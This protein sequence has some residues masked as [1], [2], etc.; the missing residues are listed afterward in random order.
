MTFLK[1]ISVEVALALHDMQVA[2]HGGRRG[3]VN[4][5]QLEAAL[6]R[7]RNLLNYAEPDIA[8]LAASYAY[9]LAN[10]H[11]FVDGNK[12]VS[13]VVTYAFL[14]LNGFDLAIEGPEAVTLWLDLASGAIDE[15]A[16][17]ARIRP[18]LVAR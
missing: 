16:L 1:W 6:H 15:N 17:A 9:G 7:L 11:P 3:S 18:A 8:D 14:D 5:G 10:D 2:E 13:F 4:L 12:R